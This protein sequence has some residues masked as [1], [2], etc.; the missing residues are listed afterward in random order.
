VN[1][2]S[3]V[4][5]KDLPVFPDFREIRLEDKD[6]FDRFL[7]A[8]QIETSELTFTNVFTW[9]E[10]YRFEW[11]TCEGCLCA[12]ARPET[13]PPFF[14]PPLGTGAVGSCVLRCLTYMNELGMS[15]RICRVPE[16]MILEHVFQNPDVRFTFDR[17]NADYVYRSRDLVFLEGRKLHRK[18]NHVKKFKQNCSYKLVPLTPEL[19]A[20]CLLLEAEWCDLRHCEAVPGLA[21]EERAIREALLNLRVLGFTGLAVKIDGRVEAFSLGEPLNDTTAVIHVEKA[22]PRYDGLYQMINQA[23]CEGAWS[24]FEFINR[25]QDLGDEGLRKAKLSYFP[26]HLSHKYIVTLKE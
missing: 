10:C 1:K 23:F 18:R 16:T 3:E 8:M 11:T 20:D 19:V 26:C 24:D 13:G 6:I 12:L 21:G 9:R 5:V 7:A 17:D 15:P 22:N 14:L 25:E 2:V 4:D